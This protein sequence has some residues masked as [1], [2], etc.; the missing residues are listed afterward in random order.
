MLFLF[1]N[2]LV[3]AMD[4]KVFFIQLPSPAAWE[5]L[6][7]CGGNSL[8]SVSWKAVLEGTRRRDPKQSPYLRVTAVLFILECSTPTD[9]RDLS[10][11]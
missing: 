11:T 7:Y 9:M 5:F 6:Q 8:L 4:F 1:I 2:V 3:S 10:F